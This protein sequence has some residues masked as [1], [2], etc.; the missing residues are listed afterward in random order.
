MSSEQSKIYRWWSL[1]FNIEYVYQKLFLV[2][3]VSFFISWVIKY[4]VWIQFSSLLHLEEMVL[5][6]K[7]LDFLQIQ[8][9][10]LCLSGQ[11]FSLF[12]ERFPL[13][14]PSLRELIEW[15]CWQLKYRIQNDAMADQVTIRLNIVRNIF[16]FILIRFFVK[17]RF[18]K[19]IFRS[20]K[21]FKLF[22]KII[23][24]YS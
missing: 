22:R 13:L 3:F 11:L 15:T 16:T 19:K 18:L 1:K 4:L 10:V 2:Y 7:N 20:W 23:K 6:G 17:K 14:D 8:T 12:N 24:F 9:S 21:K 5:I